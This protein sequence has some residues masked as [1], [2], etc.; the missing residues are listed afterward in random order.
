MAAEVV[1]A[2]DVPAVDVPAVH[3]AS[4]VGQRAPLTVGEL[5][6]FLSNR[7][8][9]ADMPL[10]VLDADGVAAQLE[11]ALEGSRS[12]FDRLGLLSSPPEGTLI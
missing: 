9:P 2:M 6:R 7:G 8:L 12:W 4:S 10:S 3:P 1:P 5:A 11:G